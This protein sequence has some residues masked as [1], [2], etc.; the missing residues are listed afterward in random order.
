M[1]FEVRE[2]FPSEMTFKVYNPDNGN[3]Y[4]VKKK[5]DGTNSVTDCYGD[6]IRKSDQPDGLLKAAKEYIEAEE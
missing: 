5:F 1:S 6:P 4:T 2:A 3:S